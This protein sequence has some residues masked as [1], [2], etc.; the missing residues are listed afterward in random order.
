MKAGG[1]IV[2]SRVG[3]HAESLIC[4]VFDLEHGRNRKIGIM[5]EPVGTR[6][7]NGMTKLLGVRAVVAESF[8]RIHRSNLVGMGV[9]PLQF[10]QE[11]WHKLG[12]TGEEIVTIRGLTELAPR[13]QLIVEMYRASD[14]R[15]ARFPV[16][17][18]IDTPTELEY[19]KNGGVLNYVLRNLARQG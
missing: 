9:L 12:L 8:E 6:E 18:R 10:L 15:I 16:R 4:E 2:R 5:L 1:A 7:A 11:G 19:F 17:C 14:G 13:K 3:L